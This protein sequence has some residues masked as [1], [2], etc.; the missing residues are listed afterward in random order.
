MSI[1]GSH[2]VVLSGVEAVWLRAALEDDAVADAD[3]EAFLSGLYD[4]LEV[5][6]ADVG[7]LEVGAVVTALG[8]PEYGV[9]FWA[10]D[11][12]AETIGEWHSE[13][14]VAEAWLGVHEAEAPNVEHF[15]VERVVQVA[16][17]A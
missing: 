6:A 4:A 1:D 7:V 17:A 14:R 12:E 3:E 11:G 10:L 9:A 13:R 2:T 8:S 16:G 5:R 15:L